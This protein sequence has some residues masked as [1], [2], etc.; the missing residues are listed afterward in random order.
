[1]HYAGREREKNVEEKLMIS[2]KGERE[3]HKREEHN[4]SP[5]SKLCGKFIL[6]YLSAKIISSIF[7][8]L[9]K[10]DRNVIY[11]RKGKKKLLFWFL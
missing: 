3:E 5:N 2:F 8:E 11:E 6:S 4:F 7:S 9:K 1:M 10:K